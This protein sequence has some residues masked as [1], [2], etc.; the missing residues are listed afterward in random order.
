ML[1]SVEIAGIAVRALDSKQA[2]DIQILKT[3]KASLEAYS[4]SLD[5][6]LEQAVICVIAGKTV[7]D[8]MPDRFD[9]I[10]N[11]MQ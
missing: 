7:I 8:S 6:A 11:L 5:Q 10:E 9:R 3:D 1:S 4:A 2:R